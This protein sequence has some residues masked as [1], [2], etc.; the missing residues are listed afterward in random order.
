MRAN[1]NSF[2]G[3]LRNQLTVFS[4]DT[5]SDIWEA[6]GCFDI[7]YNAFNCR[8]G[9]RG[10]RYGVEYQGDLK[11]GAF[12]A[13]T[14][15]ARNETETASASQ[16]PDPNDGSFTPIRARQTTNSVFAEHRLTLGRSPRPHVRRPRRRD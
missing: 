8:S 13:L 9:Y 10:A 7:S 2:G 12:G 3:L 1:A 14:F 6:E 4:N 15:G 11:L 5:N 16:S